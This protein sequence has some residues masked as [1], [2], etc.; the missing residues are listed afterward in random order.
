MFYKGNP[1]LYN[2]ENYTRLLEKSNRILSVISSVSTAGFVASLAGIVS[3][4]PLKEK[5]LVFVTFNK[6]DQQLVRLIPE[7]IDKTTLE[8]LT[9]NYLREYVRKR[10]TINHV[11]DKERGQ[12]LGFFTDPEWFEYYRNL[13]SFSNPDSP[14]LKYAKEGLTREATVISIMPLPDLKNGYQVEFFTIDRRGGYEVNRK[15]YIATFTI[16]YQEIESNTEIAAINPIGLTVANY[17]L[18]ERINPVTTTETNK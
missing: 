15:E 16:Y 4:F 10:E 9:E 17:A 18:R 12:W 5:E 13:M 2:D 14:I 6:E 7:G 11:D 8:Q 1:E 3:L